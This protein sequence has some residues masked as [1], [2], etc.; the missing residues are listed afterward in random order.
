MA[1]DIFISYKSERRKAAEHLAAVLRLYGYSVWFDYQLVR[2]AD[3][4]R[5]IDRKIREV[6]AVVVLWCTMSVESRWVAE[7]ADFAHELG[8][9]IPARI[10]PCGL[11]AGFRLLDTLDLSAWDGSPRSHVLDPLIDSAAERVG[12]PPQ[13]DYARLREFEASW[14]HYGAL[15]LKAFA[16]GTPLADESGAHLPPGGAGAAAPP[17]AAAVA[18]NGNGYDLTATAE[19]E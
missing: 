7:E 2:G 13:I 6:K 12:R 4:G 18:A 16:L 10:E 19:R 9:L 17:P 15:P 11:R 5:Q 1:D 8:T 3:F 14:R